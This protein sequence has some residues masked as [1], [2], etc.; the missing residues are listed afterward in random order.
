VTALSQVSLCAVDCV[1]PQ[2]A[3]EAL[4]R[5]A[6]RLDFGDVLLITD[7]PV[8]F[9][10]RVVQI[11]RLR[12]RDAYSDFLIRRLIE[13]VRTPF[14]LIVQWDGFVTDARRWQDE[15]LLVDYIG[16]PWDWYSD[17]LTVGNGGFSLR[18]RKLLDACAQYAARGY[19]IDTNEDTL[20]CRRWRRALESEVKIK[21][22]AP[23]LARQ[24]SYERSLPA[25]PTFGFHGL[26]NMWRHVDDS[27]LEELIEA[28]PLSTVR[29]VEYLELMLSF[30]SQKKFRIVESMFRRLSFSMS[31]D[32][33]LAMLNPLIGDSRLSEDILSLCVRLSAQ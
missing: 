15:F 3:V 7:T 18:S 26:F 23:D 27:K 19:A 21:F 30:L 2:L 29:G 12:S 1:A 5:S 14:V 20:I 11:D 31:H 10:G 8:D 16:A 33:M 6:E 28:V 9:G 4:S 22:A 13:F 24:F 25:V 32:E 17:G